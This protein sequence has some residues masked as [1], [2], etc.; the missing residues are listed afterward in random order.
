MRT[1]QSLLIKWRLA[2]WLGRVVF[3]FVWYHLFSAEATDQFVGR[4]QRGERCGC[5]RDNPP[6]LRL[7]SIM[8]ARSKCNG[9]TLFHVKLMIKLIMTQIYVYL[10][11]GPLFGSAVF[12]DKA[13]FPPTSL[14]LGTGPAN[15]RQSA[16]D[17]RPLHQPGKI[18]P[19]PHSSV[20]FIRTSAG[21]VAV[22]SQHFIGSPSPHHAT[23]ARFVLVFG[24][25]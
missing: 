6:V 8:L 2:L 16:D 13:S 3:F 24:G 9:A 4:R 20:L 5:A 14:P 17:R 19:P 12:D 18:V 22:P 11:S 15:A 21:L 10:F 25:E 23:S 1:N 7:C